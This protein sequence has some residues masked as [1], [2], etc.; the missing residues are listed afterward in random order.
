MLGPSALPSATSSVVATLVRGMHAGIASRVFSATGPAA[1]PTEAIHDGITRAISV[2]AT[3]RL[4]R[5]LI[6]LRRRSRRP[7]SGSWSSCTADAL[8]SGHGLGSHATARR[9]ATAEATANGCTTT[10]VSARFARLGQRPNARRNTGPAA[11]PMTGVHH[12]ARAGRPL[13]GRSG[14]AQRL[15]LRRPATAW[16][17]RRD[18]SCRAPWLTASGGRLGK[19]A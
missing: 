1:A 10:W 17:D 4:S 9:E 19:M 13:D 14:C 5:R 18:Q 7:L 12:R 3:N 11:Q 16:L 2:T 15:P 8:P 6:R